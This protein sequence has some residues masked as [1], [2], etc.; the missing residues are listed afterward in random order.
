MKVVSWAVSEDHSHSGFEIA[1]TYR[2]PYGRPVDHVLLGRLIGAVRDDCVA[3]RAELLGR[4]VDDA[5]TTARLTELACA[6]INVTLGGVPPVLTEE[7]AHS[8]VGAE[9]RRLARNG[10]AAGSVAMFAAC[11][12]MSASERLAA[13]ITS[14]D[15]LLGVMD[16][17]VQTRVARWGVAGRDVAAT[18]PHP[19]AD[20]D[21]RAE[22]VLE[23]IEA[24]GRMEPELEHGDHPL[25]TS[26]Q[27]PVH[28]EQAARVNEPIGLAGPGVGAYALIGQGER[29]LVIQHADHDALPGGLVRAGEPVEQAL[30]RVLLDQLGVTIAFLDFCTAVECG[31]TVPGGPP[32]SEVALLFDVT[33]TD[34][35]FTGSMASSHRW[36]ESDHLTALRPV[37]VRNE[38]IA[39]TLTVEH[40]WKAWTP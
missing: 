9:F 4:L 27:N 5:V 32:S 36:V 38:L 19:S 25:S 39:G 11:A 28:S 1:E 18:Q 6:A 14:I 30:R 23:M 29:L 10:V 26:S 3:C 21:R 31:I 24:V 17:E 33:L 13:A 20:R 2:D 7:K 35:A 22:L 40:P 15:L 8:L 12:Q 34:L 37:T 16:L